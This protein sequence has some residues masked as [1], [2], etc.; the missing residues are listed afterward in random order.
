MILDAGRFFIT[1]TDTAVGKTWICGSILNQWGGK[2]PYYIKPIQTGTADG[3]DDLL[4]VTAVAGVR[5][6]TL[7]RYPLPR[8]PWAAA[9][10]AG[11]IID[12]PSLVR[13]C[14]NLLAMNPVALVE[15][16]GGALVPITETYDMVDLMKDLGLPVW[17]V[18]RTALGTMNHTR[19]TVEAILSRGVT[20]AGVILNPGAGGK[21]DDL[22][23][24]NREFLERR[25]GC[26][27]GIWE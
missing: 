27:V 22:A 2:D 25:L 10:V 13:E 3:D 12:V 19:L 9:K 15:G 4:E 18:A 11:E 1:G 16:A 26:R 8:A 24:E 5:G 14:R 6:V 7:R 17:V 23:R 21:V 20:L